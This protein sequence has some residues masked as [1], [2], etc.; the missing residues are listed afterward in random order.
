MSTEPV[1][2]LKGVKVICFHTLLQVLEGM[3]QA[4]EVVG[5]TEQQGLANLYG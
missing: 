3:P 2:I 1:L 5:K 4:I